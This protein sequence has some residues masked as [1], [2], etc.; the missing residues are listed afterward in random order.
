MIHT[1]YL[2]SL[3]TFDSLLAPPTSLTL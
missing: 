2:F 1:V 3:F